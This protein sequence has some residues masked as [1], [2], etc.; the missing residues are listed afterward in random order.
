MS[1]AVDGYTLTPTPACGGC[2]GLTTS[3]A[4]S[5]RVNGLTNGTPYTFTVKAHNSIGFSADSPAS[6]SVTPQ[7]N[8]SSCQFDSFPA[9]PGGSSELAVACSLSTDIGGA[10]NHYNIED[11]PQA[12]WNTGAG[13]NVTTTAATAATSST[14][15]A[16]AG[17]FGPQDVNDTIAGPGIPSNTFIKA[18]AVAGTSA[19]LDKA[20][21]SPGVA[22]GAVLTVNNSDG[23]T[24]TTRSSPQ[25]RQPAAPRRLLR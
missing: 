23:R 9:I 5:T 10:G 12:Q 20:V 25:P 16:A 18:V 15:T 19:T 22:S 2:T 24:F 8:G 13:R 4:N 6:P 14:I 7:A 1:P 11:F 21:G 17:H 3:A